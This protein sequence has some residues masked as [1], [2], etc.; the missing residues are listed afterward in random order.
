MVII[1]KLIRKNIFI[2]IL[3]LILINNYSYANE[4]GVLC[5]NKDR[6]WEWL[7]NE[8]VKGEWNKKMVGYYFI[9][10]F[11]IEGGQDKVNE[12]RYKCFQKFGTRLSFPQPAQSSLSAWSVFAISETQL[13]E[14]IVEFC[15][16][17]RN[18]MTCRF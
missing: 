4:T 17:F 18:V 14:G 15:T 13:V 12:L 11:L 8:K 9:N 5:S 16:F 6:D 1:S 2:I 3:F 7:Q 10:Y